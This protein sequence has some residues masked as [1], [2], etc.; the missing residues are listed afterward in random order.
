MRG[1]CLCLFGVHASRQA[2]INRR[3][4]ALK[5]RRDKVF[6]LLHR[7]GDQVATAAVPPI[8]LVRP[9]RDK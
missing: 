4:E 9:S 2:I 8:S 6:H 5:E 1:D 7:N 3:A